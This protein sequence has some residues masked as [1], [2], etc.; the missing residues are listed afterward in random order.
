MT[1]ADGKA[2]D[3]VA[4]WSNWWGSPQLFAQLINVT[5][6]QA[7][8]A[9][10]C[11]PDV[12][13]V[14][15]TNDHSEHFRSIEEFLARVSPEMLH[16]FTSLNCAIHG[17]QCVYLI[18]IERP[19]GWWPRTSTSQM[20]VSATAAD[21]TYVNEHMRDGVRAIIC[22]A[23]RGYQPF[24]GPSSWPSV[25]APRSTYD[26]LGHHL[27][28]VFDFSMAAVC[29]VGI[30]VGAARLSGFH[31]P[32]A[33]SVIGSGLAGAIVVLLVNFAV[34]SIEV[35]FL[36]RTRLRV[37]S[38]RLLAAATG[39]LGAQVLAFLAGK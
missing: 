30:A 17:T 18:C 1:Q 2:P 10:S 8:V 14:I 32:P 11:R 5:C 15:A 12:D 9:P 28:Q 31:E 34:P 20:T 25:V 26:R 29:G 13:M 19:R 36:G 33:W 6:E 37:T 4:W 24:W 7:F 21:G 22:E 27:R 16:A 38:R 39:S 3:L 23:R 35:A